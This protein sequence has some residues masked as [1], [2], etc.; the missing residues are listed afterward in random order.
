MMCATSE[1][2]LSSYEEESSKAHRYVL[3]ELIGQGVFGSVFKGRDTLT[4]KTVAIKVSKL[5]NDETLKRE[6]EVLNYI[7]YSRVE[8]KEG[9]GKKTVQ[10]AIGTKF[11][12]NVDR[13]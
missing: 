11:R 5:N 3:K 1:A 6:I 10:V 7:S 4:K 9:L 2:I 13:I 12:L 8:G